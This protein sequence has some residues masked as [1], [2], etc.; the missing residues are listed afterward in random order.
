M[1]DNDGNVKM[2]A[3]KT[4]TLA[5]ITIPAAVSKA[6]QNPPPGTMKGLSCVGKS[7]YIL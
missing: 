4:K 3:W 5:E 1:V 6:I 7:E 2:M